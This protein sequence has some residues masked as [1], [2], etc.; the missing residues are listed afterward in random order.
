[1]S[2]ALRQRC[3]KILR[4]TAS[5]LPNLQVQQPVLIA[6]LAVG[7]D[8]VATRSFRHQRGMGC[9]PLRGR[10]ASR[11]LLDEVETVSLDGGG[12]VAPLA[13]GEG[14]RRAVLVF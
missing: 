9:Q 10:T 2:W 6:H 1:M 12:E 3:R 7:S 13:G 5:F 14:E 4:P 8:D 11:R